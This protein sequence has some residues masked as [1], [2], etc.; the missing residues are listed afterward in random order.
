M[1]GRLIPARAG[2][3]LKSKS[4]APR[5]TAHPRACGENGV[6]GV[7]GRL[8]GGSS[9]RVRGKPERI[10]RTSSATGLIP[11]RAGKT[12]RVHRSGLRRRAHPRACG[13]NSPTP[14]SA[15]LDRGSSP[16]VRGKLRSLYRASYGDG[17]IPARA[18]KTYTL[19]SPAGS[20][21][22]HPRAC[23]ENALG[24][25]S[26]SLTSGSSPRVRG[27]RWSC[28]PR[29]RIRGLIPARAGKTSRK[30]LATSRRLAHPRACGE[31]LADLRDQ[32]YSA[33]SS[34]RVRGKR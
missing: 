28:R 21:S 25:A 23:G 13:E 11:A 33:G 5:S 29:R 1:T 15:R 4:Y 18:G 31:N 3:T 24:K 14:S 27:K 6:V 7:W 2:K 22:A 19:S 34:P 16:R 26:G 17:L 20:L 10:R 30:S 9:P 12:S 32:L 8:V